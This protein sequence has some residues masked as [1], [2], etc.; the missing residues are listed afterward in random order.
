MSYPDTGITVLHTPQAHLFQ[1]QGEPS[2]TNVT[3]TTM[4]LNLERLQG[5][6][7]EPFQKSAT[8]MIGAP[9]ERIWD[10]ATWFGD[11]WLRR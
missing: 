11:C 3:V 1:W 4:R 2:A 7:R 8:R 5:A 9:S 10:V 6:A